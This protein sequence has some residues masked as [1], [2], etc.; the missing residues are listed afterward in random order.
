MIAICSYG[1]CCQL[2]PQRAPSAERE[3]SAATSSL[4]LM[5]SPPSSVRLTLSAAT[6]RFHFRRTVQR[7]AR[8]LAQQTKQPLADIVEFNHRPSADRP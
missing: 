4:P 8:R 5:I 2:M 6:D 3:P 7:D 1:C